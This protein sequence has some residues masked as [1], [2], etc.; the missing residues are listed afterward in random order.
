[1]DIN[2]DEKLFDNFSHNAKD[3]VKDRTINYAHELIKEANLIEEGQRQDGAKAEVTSNIVMQA[4]LV[5]RTIGSNNKKPK[6]LIACRIISVISCLITGFFFDP[7]GYKDNLTMLIAFIISLSIACISTAVAIFKEW[8]R[9]KYL[10]Q[11]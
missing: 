11:R 3:K 7:N 8:T 10:I 4:S 6:W 2:L 1:M 9:W 5:K